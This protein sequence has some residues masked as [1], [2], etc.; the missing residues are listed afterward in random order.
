MA[1]LTFHP[2][3]IFQQLSSSIEELNLHGLKLSAK[4]LSEH[5]LGLNQEDE[6]GPSSSSDFIP[7]YSNQTLVP[8]QE[9]EIIHFAN[10][11][12]VANEFQRCAHFLRSKYENKILTS[13]L[14]IFLLT[15]SLYLAGEKIKEQN[16]VEASGHILLLL[17]LTSTQVIKLQTK[18]EIQKRNSMILRALQ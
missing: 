5:L 1:G 13:Q 11:L 18:K 16:I 6:I 9:K 12:L 4:W 8:K 17:P 15:Y 7:L 2:K 14:G 10:L 3:E